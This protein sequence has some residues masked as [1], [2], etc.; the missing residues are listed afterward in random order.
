MR[1]VLVGH[2][3]VQV[4]CDGSHVAVDRPLVIVQHDNQPA[5]L[6]GDIVQRLERDTVG[7]SGVSSQRNNVFAAARQIACHG[8]AQRGG[9]RSARVARPIS[10]VFAFGAQHEAVQSTRL[11]NRLKTLATPGKELMNVC[12]MAHVKDEFVGRGVED[13]MQS[14]RQLDH[15][16]I[17]TEVSASLRE[18]KNQSLANFLRKRFKL[19]NR[20]LLDI[21]GRVDGVE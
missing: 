10:V 1:D 4:P 3:L 7:K 14:K 13:I 19:R 15:A 8:H 18:S 16:E 2:D 5:G 11:A 17:R 9:E 6:V 20:K 12:L 21:C